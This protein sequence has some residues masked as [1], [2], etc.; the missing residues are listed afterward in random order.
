MSRKTANPFPPRIRRIGIP[1]P[2][3]M[4]KA[5]E[6]DDARNLLKSWGIE[7]VVGESLLAGGDSEYL[8][9]DDESR[10]S[11]LNA[12]IRDESLDLILCARGGYGSMRILNRIDWTTLKRRKLPILG[13]SDITAMHLGMLAKGAGVPVV[14]TMANNF[15]K[16]CAHPYCGP[17]L[18]RAFGVALDGAGP[19]AELP[20]PAGRHLETLKAGSASGPLMP[21]NLTL[22]TSLMGSEFMPSLKGAMLLIEDIGEKPRTLDRMLAQLELSGALGEVSALIFGDFRDCGREDELKLT[23]SRYLGSV[24]GPVLRGVPFGHSLP[25]MAF[26]MGETAVVEDG[27]LLLASCNS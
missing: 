4:P 13:Y 1:A 10:L 14:C 9:A 5:H 26:L 15:K 2:A 22:L 19:L 16:A 7:A 8:S 20:L 21:V 6:I 27:R 3:S 17:A 24:K 11:D 12:M 25:S 18:A 23:F